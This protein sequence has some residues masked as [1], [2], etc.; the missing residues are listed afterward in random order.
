MTSRITQNDII[1]P[2]RVM[3]LDSKLVPATM[4]GWKYYTVKIRV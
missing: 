3:H 4:D 1:L 2:Y